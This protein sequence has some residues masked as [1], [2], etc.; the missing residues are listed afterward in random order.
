MKRTTDI[1]RRR[2]DIRDKCRIQGEDHSPRRRKGPSQ[3]TA[4]WLGRACMSY[5]R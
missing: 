3:I 5:M 1:T 4:Q 2:D